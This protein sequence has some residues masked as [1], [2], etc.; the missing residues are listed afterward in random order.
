MRPEQ[1]AVFER[2]SATTQAF[3]FR[4]ARRIAAGDY[5]GEVALHVKRGRGGSGSI[6]FIRWVQ[7]EDGEALKGGES[8]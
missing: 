6:S 3:L 8:P 4:V 2:L 1:L 7:I 5:E